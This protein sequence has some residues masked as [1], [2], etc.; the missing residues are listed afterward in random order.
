MIFPGISAA[1]NPFPLLGA[2]RTAPNSD[3]P[4]ASI[5]RSAKRLAAVKRPPWTIRVYVFGLSTPTM[6]RRAIHGTALMTVPALPVA[7][8][9][10][11]RFPSHRPTSGVSHSHGPRM[12]QAQRTLSGKP[13]GFRRVAPTAHPRPFPGHVSHHRPNRNARHLDR[14]LHRRRSR[15]HASATADAHRARGAPLPDLHSTRQHAATSDPDQEPGEC[16]APWRSRLGLRQHCHEHGA[17]PRVG[18]AGWRKC[19]PHALK[20]SEPR[21]H[22]PG[23]SR[24][25][26][27][28]HDQIQD[29]GRDP[30]GAERPKALV[31]LARAGQRA[32]EWI[33]D[34]QAGHG[35]ISA[36]TIARPMIAAGQWARSI[37]RAHQ[38]QGRL[39]LSRRRRR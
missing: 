15:S 36:P 4:R 21:G 14:R 20:R 12:V 6:L 8:R 25:A 7:P 9:P 39:A 17:G 24:F 19:H 29:P 13:A 5:D 27:H 22:P 31:R 35:A 33:T 2:R 32:S 37:S 34:V 18:G 28:D 38:N 1:T 30:A 11:V 3:P 10:R 16:G 26:D 23:V